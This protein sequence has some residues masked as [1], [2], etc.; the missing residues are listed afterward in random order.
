[1]GALFGVPTVAAM[2]S[3]DRA[4][5]VAC[6]TPTG[7]WLDDPPLRGLLDGAA[8]QLEHVDVLMLNT[9][10]DE[11]F[12][13]ADSV[14][15]YEAIRARSKRQVFRGGAHDDWSEDMIAESIDFL[16]HGAG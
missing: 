4:V 6:G 11:V 3:V 14:A 7:S 16:R 2:Q 12:P 10:D 13:V 5:L 9:N 1:M 15:L 8:E